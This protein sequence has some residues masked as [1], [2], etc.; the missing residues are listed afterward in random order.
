MAVLGGEVPK[1]FH[2]SISENSFGSILGAMF[3]RAIPWAQQLVA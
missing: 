2:I 1:Q 3:V